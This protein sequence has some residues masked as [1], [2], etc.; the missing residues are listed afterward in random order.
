VVRSQLLLKEITMK[1]KPGKKVAFCH[2]VHKSALKQ[3]DI[4]NDVIAA[5]KIFIPK[6][7]KYDVIKWDSRTDRVTFTQSPDWDTADEP[8][9][10][11]RWTVEPEKETKFR[12]M[13]PNNP[14]IYHHK[15]MFV[16]DNYKGFDVEESKKRSEAW[17]KLKPNKSK[18][19]YKK[20]WEKEVVPNIKG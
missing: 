10:G 5:A 9:V 12:R 2:Y 13:N 16:K 18:I 6:S 1:R 8:V 11:D 19:G 20:Y 4:P 14:Q 3:S 15:W 7:F 17:E